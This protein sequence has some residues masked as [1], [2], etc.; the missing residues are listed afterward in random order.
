[1]FAFLFVIKGWTAFIVLVSPQFMQ[2]DFSVF[3]ACSDM[4]MFVSLDLFK[5]QGKMFSRWESNFLPWFSVNSS[6]VINA[7]F[8]SYDLK[9]SAILINSE[10][11]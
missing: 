10:T 4:K 2:I 3:L 7:F 8:E 6:S 11:I 1:M 5:T 9:E